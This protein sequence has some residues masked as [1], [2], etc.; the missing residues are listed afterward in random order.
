MTYP[1]M[2][3]RDICTEFSITPDTLRQYEAQKLVEPMSY[4]ARRYYSLGQIARLKIILRAKEFGFSVES[5]AEL[6]EA[7]QGSHNDPAQMAKTLS[8]ARKQVVELEQIQTMLTQSIVNVE[9]EIANLSR[10]MSQNALIQAS[11][12]PTAP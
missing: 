12:I 9:T 8:I 1:L 3:S 5:I 2:T 10:I 7:L 4:G 6:I 11:V